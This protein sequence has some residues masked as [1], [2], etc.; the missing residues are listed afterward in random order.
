MKILV[1]GAAGFIGSHV[2]REMISHGHEVVGIDSLSEVLYTREPRLRNLQSL[3]ESSA[4]EFIEMDLGSPDV[5]A[6]IRRV[7]CVV[8]EAAI[9]GLIPSWK[10]F[11]DYLY[12]NV[13]AL[14]N[15]L[16][17]LVLHP[18][19]Y[20]VQASTS[21]VY[22]LHAK[23]TESQS[24]QPISPYGISKLSAEMLVAAY[25]KSFGVRSAI[26]RYFSVFGAGQRPDMAY[27]RFIARLMAGDPIQITGDGRQKRSNTHV[28]DIA[29]ATRLACE[30]QPESLIANV[31]GD[32]TIELRDAVE[33]LADELDVQPSIEW[34]ERVPGDQMHTQGDASLAR[35][36][37]GW[38]P[39]WSLEQ[40]LRDQV[41]AA[42]G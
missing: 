42:L 41:Q 1:T 35:A 34:V 11:E 23:G 20:L 32:E 36:S 7:D 6:L 39:R 9:P 8:N 19:V 38:K 13:T 3:Q 4:F 40:G 21:S 25:G 30:I 16:D 2:C 28:Q 12:S 15:L 18:D 29:H 10:R 27:A 14:K 33:I 31:C 22:G 37:L 17:H 5:G 24:L 26:L